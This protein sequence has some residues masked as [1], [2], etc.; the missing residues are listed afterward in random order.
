MPEMTSKSVRSHKS[1]MRRVEQAA[2]EVH[3]S[4]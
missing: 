4:F 2:L 1:Y 3:A